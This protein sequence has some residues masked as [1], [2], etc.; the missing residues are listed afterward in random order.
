[1]L[2]DYDGAIQYARDIQLFL[3]KKAVPRYSGG[4][5]FSARMYVLLLIETLDY[6]KAKDAEDAEDILLFQGESDNPSES[7]EDEEADEVEYEPMEDD[8]EL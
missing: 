4:S 5:M 2:R 1:M 7:D 3:S 6:L 8:L